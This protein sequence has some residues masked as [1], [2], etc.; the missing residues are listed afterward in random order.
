LFGEWAWSLLLVLF[1]RLDGHWWTRGQLF[2]WAV[3][4]QT[5]FRVAAGEWR[6]QADAQMQALQVFDVLYAL[7]YLVIPLLFWYQQILVVSDV[8]NCSQQPELCMLVDLDHFGTAQFD[9]LQHFLQDLALVEFSWFVEQV[10]KVLDLFEQLNWDAFVEG[11]LDFGAFNWAGA[12]V[13]DGL[14][15]VDE[16]TGVEVKRLLGWF[17]FLRRL[18]FFEHFKIFQL[19]LPDINLLLIDNWSLIDP[20]TKLLKFELAHNLPDHILNTITVI[21][22]GVQITIILRDQGIKLML[23]ENNKEMLYLIGAFNK[24]VLGEELEVGTHVEDAID[25]VDYALVR[26]EWGYLFE[27]V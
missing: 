14:K 16:K 26:D 4:P 25:A 5:E 18:V 24:F 6:C 12:F 3:V 7:A 2:W 8:T 19:K 13:G 21:I 9:L 20:G 23:K 11:E 10:Q 1:G 27:G 22:L 17:E 15:E